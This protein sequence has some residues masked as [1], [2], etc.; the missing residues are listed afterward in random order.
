MRNAFPNTVI[1]GLVSIFTL[2]GCSIAPPKN[3]SETIE[4][5]N[6]DEIGEYSLSDVESW[7]T[8]YYSNEY[9]DIVLE[10]GEPWGPHHMISAYSRGDIVGDDNLAM[11][12]HAHGC[13]WNVIAC[14]PTKQTVSEM[15]IFPIRNTSLLMRLDI[16]NL[17]IVDRGQHRPATYKSGIIKLSECQ[18][19]GSTW[20]WVYEHPILQ[21]RRLYNESDEQTKTLHH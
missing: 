8:F 5:F 1:I 16:S 7:R 19:D 12:Y 4:K 21:R 14:I 11:P 9:S 3:L 17:L 6:W 2:E 15:R 18:V 10:V 20:S 13:P